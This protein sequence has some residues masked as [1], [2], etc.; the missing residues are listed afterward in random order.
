[1]YPR[2]EVPTKKRL[3][4]WK[5]VQLAEANKTLWVPVLSSTGKPLMP[6]HPARARQLV[7]K[8]K[9]I[10][11]YLKGIFCIQLTER[12]DGYLQPIAIG[13]DPG[14]MMNGYCVKSGDHTYINI[15][16]NAKNGKAV[17]VAV[18][19]RA[20]ARRARRGRKTPCRQPRFNN[21]SRKDFISPLS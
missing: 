17:K 21:R 14:S 20:N 6:C 15:Q 10:K 5:A 3:P 11:R 1:M 4:T 7:K 16:Q 19:T 12:E 13:V 2:K 8:G 9:A 18:E